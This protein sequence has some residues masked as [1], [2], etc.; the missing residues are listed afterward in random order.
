MSEQRL[1]ALKAP[2]RPGFEN[3]IAGPNQ[4]LV[5][6]LAQGL[7]HGAWYFLAGPAGSGRTHLLNAVFADRHRRGE[8]VGFMAL[9]VRANRA[10]LDEASADW[11][12]V[13]DIDTLAGDEDGE[14]ALFN[15]LNRWRSEHVGVLLS[16]AGRE[17]F[18]LP[19]LRSRLGQ[20]TR[21]TLKPLEEADLAALVERLSSEHEVVLGRG[22]A[23]YLLKRTARNPAAIARLIES[24]AQRAL[25]ER[26]TLSVPL[27]REVIR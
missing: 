14:R 5:D 22:A 24:L 18:E 10:L 16:G 25:S 4:A 27:I 7:E 13:D 2:R 26:R 3:F 9:S 6:T 1:L 11:V 8:T 21:L 20:A 19:D 23:D 15:A 17:A 12:L